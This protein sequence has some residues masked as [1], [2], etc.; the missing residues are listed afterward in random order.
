MVAWL[1][2]SGWWS[3]CVGFFCRDTVAQEKREEQWDS[4]VK[5]QSGLIHLRETLQLERPNRRCAMP[6][7]I[8]IRD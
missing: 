2:G 1:V 6:L 4:I 5:E 3:E 8:W 7:P